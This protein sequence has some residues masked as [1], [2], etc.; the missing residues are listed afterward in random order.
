M[1]AYTEQLDI[2]RTKLGAQEATWR[3]QRDQ[4]RTAHQ[5]S[6]KKPIMPIRLK[7]LIKPKCGDLT[8]IQEA[9]E[10]EENEP[11]QAGELVDDDQLA[12]YKNEE[13]NKCIQDFNLE[14]FAQML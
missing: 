2:Q 1:D 11:N 4:A 8:I 10:V 12:D 3:E 13:L 9:E 7:R 14:R 5:R 6:S